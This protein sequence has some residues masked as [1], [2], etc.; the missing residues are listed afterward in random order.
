MPLLGQATE[1]DTVWRLSDFQKEA[2]QR[3]MN[4]ISSAVASRRIHDLPILFFILNNGPQN[5]YP[6]GIIGQL[7]EGQLHILEWIFLL[8]QP[9]KTL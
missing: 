4:K 8:Y 1:A 3:I 7:P 9:K 2:L 5:V 6:F